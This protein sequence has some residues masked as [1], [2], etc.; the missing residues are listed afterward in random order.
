MLIDFMETCLE[1]GIMGEHVWELG[2][3]LLELLYGLYLD[4]LMWKPRPASGYTPFLTALTLDPKL[5]DI[6]L[7]IFTSGTDLIHVF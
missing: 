7:I 1:V 4:R 2:V 6:K 5:V 3:S